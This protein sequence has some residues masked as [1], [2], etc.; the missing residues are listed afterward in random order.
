VILLVDSRSAVDALVLSSRARGIVRGRGGDLG[1]MVDH[2]VRTAEIQP[3]DVMVTSGLGGVFPGGLSLGEVASVTAPRAGVFREAELR[4]AVD[5]GEL[6]EV[7]VVR[8]AGRAAE[9]PTAASGPADGAL[10]G[11]REG[12]P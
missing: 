10:R 8:A 7:L 12:A 5:F 4:P 3:G 1:L 6:E 9:P 2:L 11:S